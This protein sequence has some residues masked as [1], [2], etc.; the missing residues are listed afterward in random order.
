MSSSG[1]CSEGLGHGSGASGS[2][3]WG[4]GVGGWGMVV[5][6]LGGGVLDG[7]CRM[8]ESTVQLSSETDASFYNAEAF[9]MHI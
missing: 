7:W 3:G 5:S 4:G 1:K 8:F 6:G 9:E 2:G